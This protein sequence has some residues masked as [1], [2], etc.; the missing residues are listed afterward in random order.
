VGHLVGLLI[1]PGGTDVDQ[2][3]QV[4]PQGLHQG[5]G[6]R[7]LPAIVVK[8]GVKGLVLEFGPQLIGRGAIADDRFHPRHRRRPMAPVKQHHLVA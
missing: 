5:L 6:I 3:S 8:D 2:L 1:D 4:I 7:Q